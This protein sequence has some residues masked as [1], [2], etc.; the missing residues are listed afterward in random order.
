MSAE[1]TAMDADF[2][3]LT[4]TRAVRVTGY[5]FRVET[6]LEGLGAELDAQLAPFDECVGC[7]RVYTYKLIDRGEGR[8][9]RFA[10]LRD[11]DVLLEASTAS[12]LLSTLWWSVNQEVGKAW[13]KLVL[14]A[15]AVELDGA[16]VLL[17]APMESGK[18]TLTTGL[19]ER[20]FGYLT[21]EAAVVAP[22]GLVVFPYPKPI[23][24][25]RG[26]WE[27]FPDLRPELDGALEALAHN[28]W[29]L[30]PER[31]RAGA[32]GQAS[33]ARLVLFVSWS[34]DAPPADLE[35]VTAPDA[36]FTLADA[37]FNFA[38]LGKKAFAMTTQLARTAPTFRLRYSD[39]DA[40]HEAIRDQLTKITAEEAT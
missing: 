1:A 27:V 26:S 17:V 19:V 11:V 40:A 10:V 24:L 30:A 23:T 22:E 20:G 36:V 15:G 29:Y 38:A 31:I 37:S 35:A 5:S 4:T 3:P 25:D 7:D 6:N 39:M 16:A 13:G 32:L 28:Q 34:A 2:S 14:H 21:D 18:S 12:D 9:P 33:P 8:D